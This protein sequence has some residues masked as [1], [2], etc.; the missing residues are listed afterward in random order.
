MCADVTINEVLQTARC[1]FQGRAG[2]VFPP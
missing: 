2:A 1:P